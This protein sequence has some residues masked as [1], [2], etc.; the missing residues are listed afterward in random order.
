MKFL[1]T[2][3]IFFL[4]FNA[5]AQYD[6]AAGKEGSLAISADSNVFI[7]WANECVLKRGPMDASDVSKG[8][9]NLGDEKDALGKPN[10]EIV[11]L[12]DGG[13]ATLSFSYPIT[14]GTGADFAVFENSFSDTYLELALVEV[15]SNGKDFVRFPC[16]SLT[17][18]AQQIGP[19]GT[20]NPT[21][22]QNLA[23]KHRGMYGTPFDLEVLKDSNAI[24]IDSIT[25]VRIIDVVGSI[26]PKYG[27]R[28]RHGRLIN[29]PW[30]T[31]F[32]AGGFDLD[33]VGVIH[34]LNPNSVQEI[35]S[36]KLF[37]NPCNS[38]HTIRIEG[39]EQEK[40]LTL[41]NLNGQKVNTSIATSELEVSGLKPGCYLLTGTTTKG[42][43]REK[44]VIYE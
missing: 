12:G 43:V 1:T 13:M 36:V 41:L 16:I 28:D 7:D 40:E 25:H 44:L 4:A 32:E 11:T 35:I 39:I 10:S 38:C 33:A 29:D 3:I 24:N 22:I 37:P 18:T 9:S 15:S 21:K 34:S 6:P 26:D 14:N 19:F 23:G 20:L 30:P 5:K 42:V 2:I 27:N 31:D 8:Y 17:D